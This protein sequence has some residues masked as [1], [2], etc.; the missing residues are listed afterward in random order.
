[1]LYSKVLENLKNAAKLN[2]RSTEKQKNKKNINNLVLLINR[3]AFGYTGKLMDEG[4]IQRTKYL[5]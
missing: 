4:E 3:A 5:A 2:K 1:M